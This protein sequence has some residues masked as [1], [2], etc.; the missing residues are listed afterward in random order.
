MRQVVDASVVACWFFEEELTPAAETLL[1]GDDELLAP[2]LI[3]LEMTR[4][5]ALRMARGEL[6]ERTA[7]RILTEL[8]A[9]PF[10]L[11]PARDLAA[12]ALALASRTAIRVTDAFYLALALRAACPLVTADR[13]LYDQLRVSPLA[14]HV[15]WVGALP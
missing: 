6:D 9:V 4:L 8:R 11:V 1:S 5:L 7:D 12:A 13:I 3:H 10:E 2:D 14:V 15:R